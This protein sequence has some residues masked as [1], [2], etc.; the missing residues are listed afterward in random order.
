MTLMFSTICSVNREL[1]CA[2][3]NVGGFEY[4]F[5]FRLKFCAQKVKDY[6]KTHFYILNTYDFGLQ[7][8]E[9]LE[10]LNVIRDRWRKKKMKRKNIKAKNAI[11][12]IESYFINVSGKKEPTFEIQSNESIHCMNFI[13][14]PAKL[15]H[16]NN[17]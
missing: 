7:F 17:Q 13:M 9:C 11:D 3:D 8:N 5:L 10:Y 16:L 6:D 14:A 2:S 1:F 12:Y 15:K 4:D